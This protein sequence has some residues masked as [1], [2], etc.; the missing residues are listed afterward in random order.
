MSLAAVVEGLRFVV[1]QPVILGCMS[2]DMF[3]VIFGGAT[4]LLPLYA[5]DILAVGP[6]GFGLLT[7]SF[8]L[9][10][11]AMSVVLVLRQPF[12]RVGRTLL[13]A[14]SVNS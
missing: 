12:V 4:A 3:A 11:L 14:V 7:S 1:R 13:L 8:E 10:A 2:L 6:E 9:G 5:R